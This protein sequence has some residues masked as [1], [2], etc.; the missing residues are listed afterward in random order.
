MATAQWMVEYHDWANARLLRA[1]DGID[2]TE[3]VASRAVPCGSLR[4][5][6]VHILSAEWIWRQRWPGASPAAM[7]DEREVATPGRCHRAEGC[8]A[9][10]NA[11][12]F[13]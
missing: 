7:L 1:A 12:N 5:T 8:R 10:S 4:G 2:A 9:S 3:L 6:F 13:G 11:C